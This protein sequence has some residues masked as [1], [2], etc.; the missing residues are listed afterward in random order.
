MAK[1]PFNGLKIIEYGEGISAAYCT[2]LFA[3]LGAEVI[4]IEEAGIGDKTRRHGPFPKNTP[5]SEKSGLFL[6]L[7]TD[8]MDITLNPERNRAKTYLND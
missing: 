2:R 1:R 8:K 6:Y 5:H 3:G 7:N 4:K